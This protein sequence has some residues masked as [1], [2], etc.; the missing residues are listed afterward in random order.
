MATMTFA[1]R[2]CNRGTAGTT[3][4]TP[5]AGNVFWL[6]VGNDGSAEGSYGTNRAGIERPEDT[7][8]S[9]CNLPQDLAGRCD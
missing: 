1:Q 4:F 8:A 3:S 5:G 2:V 7:G 6:I 9:A